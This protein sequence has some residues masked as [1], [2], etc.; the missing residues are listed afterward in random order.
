VDA[1][2]ER[3]SGGNEIENDPNPG[4]LNQLANEMLS[5]CFVRVRVRIS[6]FGHTKPARKLISIGRWP[7]GS[8]ASAAG[9]VEVN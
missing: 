3:K 6:A 7:S 9:C 5:V 8:L 1:E 4:D 2:R